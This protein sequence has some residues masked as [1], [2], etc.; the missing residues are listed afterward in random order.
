MKIESLALFLALAFAAALPA[1]AHRPEIAMGA[2]SSASRPIVIGDPYASQAFYG[3]L[4]GQLDY[5]S[6]RISETSDFHLSILAPKGGET[7]FIVG[8]SAPGFSE[9]LDGS[10]FQWA[11]FYEEYG[12]DW[13][14]QGPENTF[15]L[16]PENFLITVSSKSGR[17]KYAL[18]VGTNETFTLSDAISSLLVLPRLKTDFFGQPAWKVIDGKIYRYF[19]AGSAALVIVILIA[20]NSLMFFMRKRKMKNTLENL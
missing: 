17:G 4:D 3:E 15:R 7:D 13:Y 12:G 14:L 8:L 9:E 11:D 2:D 6:V 10:L 18:I 19:A 5:Y 1:C 16:I 20:V